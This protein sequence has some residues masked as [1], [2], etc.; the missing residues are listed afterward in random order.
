MQ[1]VLCFLNLSKWRF[2]CKAIKYYSGLGCSQS[3][4]N[5]KFKYWVIFQKC[6]ASSDFIP[7]DLLVTLLGSIDVIYKQS[8]DP[9]CNNTT[10]TL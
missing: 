7:W 6:V 9:A 4:I 2:Y 10:A 1:I 5:Y 8:F 3:N